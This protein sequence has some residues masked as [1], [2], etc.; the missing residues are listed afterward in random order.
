MS[1]SFINF[2]HFNILIFFSRSIGNSRMNY[3]EINRKF[4]IV[5]L[6]FYMHDF[7]ER[8]FK[9]WHILVTIMNCFSK[10]GVDPE[11]PPGYAPGYVPI[12]RYSELKLVTILKVVIIVWIVKL[13]VN[14][15]NWLIYG[16]LVFMVIRIWTWLWMYWNFC[17]NL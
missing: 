6:H 7:W 5:N 1:N 12:S 17:D 15:L 10:M 3:Y 13:N 2:N 14:I 16:Q 8:Y 9:S 4:S 11:N